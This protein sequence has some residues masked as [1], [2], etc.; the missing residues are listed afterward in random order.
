MIPRRAAWGLAVLALGG[1]GV[2]A[3]LAEA[4]CT[5]LRP[6]QQWT[7]ETALVRRLG[8]V[9]VALVIGREAARHPGQHVAYSR[10]AE[11]PQLVEP[12]SR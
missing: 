4:A 7:A 6:P 11:A 9:D 2:C 1:A 8:L 10:A 5:S 3:T 12:A